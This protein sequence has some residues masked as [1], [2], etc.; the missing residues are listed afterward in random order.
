MHRFVFIITAM[1]VLAGCNPGIAPSATPTQVQPT[2]EPTEEP[3]RAPANLSDEEIAEKVGPAT[4]LIL[5]QFAETAIEPEGVGGGSG[6]VYD[7]KNGFIVTNAHVVEG[8]SIIKVVTA[9]SNRT[10]PARVVGR[11]QC[12]DLAVLKVDNTSGLAEA[13]LGDSDTLKPGAH[14]VALGYP[15]MFQLGTDLSVTSGNVSKLH[16]QQFQYEDLIQTNADITHGNSG[17]PLVNVRGEVIGINT[18]GFYSAQGERE[19]GIN[20]AIP[21]SYAKPIIAELEKGKNRQYI[22]LNLY[23]NVFE[24]YFG[25]SE[26]MAVIGVASGSPASQVGI[27]PAD[28]L[29]KLEGTSIASEEDVCNILR[30]HADGD[31]LRVTVFRKET[32]EVLE[33]ELTIGKT[34]AAGPDVAGLKVIGRT[35]EAEPTP[36]PAASTD[37]SGSDWTIVHQANFDNN[38]AG[39]WPTDAVEG[40]QG[41]VANGMYTISISKESWAYYVSPNDSKVNLSD[42]LVAAEVTAEG[43][44]WAGLIGRY[45]NTDAGNTLYYCWF[46]NAKEFGCYK[47]VN[48]DWTQ[49]VATDKS[50]AIKPGVANILTMSVVGKQLVFLINDEVVANTTDIDPLPEGAWGIASNT[51]EGV[52][53]FNAHYNEILIA[54]HK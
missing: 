33:G 14:V 48:D 39:K 6:I 26:G 45:V 15:E 52:S 38:D 16:A 44:G 50:N 32:G 43:D 53:Q 51:I 30:S 11:S 20:F 7:L 2:R 12:D 19:P 28:L 21:I 1:L 18:L 31:Q 29:L 22:G 4:V 10:R 34:G 5:A 42:G 13:K 41:S 25:T 3:T 36:T 40:A 54:R 17:G 24:D 9:G 37:T 46:D 8:A 23:P 35:Q 49:I 27:R 47:I